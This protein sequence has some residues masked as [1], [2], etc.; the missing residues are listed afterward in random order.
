MF[1]GVYNKINDATLSAG[2]WTALDNVKN[3][4]LY[5]LA[6]SSN[7]TTASTKFEIDLGSSLAIVCVS[8]HTHNLSSAA[9]VTLKAGTTAGASDVLNSTG[10]AAYSVTF[11]A[12]RNFSTH[13]DVILD[14][15]VT[16]RYWTVEITDTGNSDGYV[17]I[18]RV[19]VWQGLT[20]ATN[21]SWGVSYGIHDNSEID[22]SLSGDFIF[23][24]RTRKRTVNFTFDFLTDAE[25]DQA[26]EILRYAGETGEV[27]FYSGSQAYDCLG[28]MRKLGALQRKSLNINA[29][30]YEIIEL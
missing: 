7:A 5:S 12:T 1:L 15:N 20:P 6:R 18:G 23:D 25:R 10:N 28:R 13:Y 17:E 8:L 29:Q 3:R 22:H 19:G 4:K 11:D 2:S 9:T 16:A 30:E 26:H 24:Q 14:A 21:F 27:L